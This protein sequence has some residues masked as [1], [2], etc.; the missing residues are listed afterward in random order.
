MIGIVNYG[1]GNISAIINI[2]EK[3]NIP[4]V[5]V[6]DSRDFDK[7]DKF[8]L[9]VVGSFDQALRL[10]RSSGMHTELENQILKKKKLLLGI[11]VGMQILGNN[12]EEGKEVGLG[13]IEGDIKKISH[14]KK[15]D[16]VRVPHM[17]WNNILIKKKINLLDKI[18]S[19]CY[20]YFLHSYHFCCKKKNNIVA[21]TNYL[22]NFT[23]IISSDNIYGI[24]FHPEKS[25][26]Q[27]EQI[28]K[29]FALNV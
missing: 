5:S 4:A 28:L 2:Y 8:V 26:D 19:K 15:K 22:Q 20:F 18:D 6:A 3:L 7:I 23:S 24:Q 12:S 13:W 9:P 14:A 25:H 11:C 16:P 29:N 27:G 21:E 1:L 10:F 17:G